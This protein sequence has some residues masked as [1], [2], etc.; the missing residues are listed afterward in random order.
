M[1]SDLAL[2][3]PTASK[4]EGLAGP[5]EERDEL[6]LS[7]IHSSKGLEWRAVFVIQARDGTIPMVVSYE[8]EPE[9]ES[10]DEDLRLLYV[11]VTR[12][13]DHLLLVWPRSVP[14]GPSGWG[15][16]SRFLVALPQE[17]FE[18]LRADEFAA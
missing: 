15:M 1:L 7:T 13:K 10:L 5:S 11:A 18:H 12:A 17:L 6:V 4:R 2:E 16:P 14:R 3:P 8:D 9:E